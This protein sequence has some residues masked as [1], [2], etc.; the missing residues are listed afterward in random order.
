MKDLRYCV[1]YFN[2][3]D[4]LAKDKISEMENGGIKHAFQEAMKAIKLSHLENK[5]SII[6]EKMIEVCSY[7]VRNDLDG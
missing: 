2:E 5:K 3:L 7:V 6:K 1:D 4:T